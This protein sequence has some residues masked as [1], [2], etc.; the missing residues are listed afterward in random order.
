ME[1]TRACQEAEGEGKTLV[2]DFI[3]VLQESIGKVGKR[4]TDW[5]V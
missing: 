3:V 4:V 5:L 1:N 2:Q